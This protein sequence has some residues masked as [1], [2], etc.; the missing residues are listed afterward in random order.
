M[1]RNDRR[2]KKGVRKNMFLD[3]YVEFQIE[4][5]DS[6]QEEFNEALG[7]D[8]ESICEIV[9]VFIQKDRVESYRQTWLIDRPEQEVVSVIMYSGESYVLLCTLKEFI[10]KMNEAN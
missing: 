10:N 2:R 9:P 3:N 8:A 7:I 5:V 1:E 4:I 6:K